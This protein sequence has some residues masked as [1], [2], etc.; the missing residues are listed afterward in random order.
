MSSVNTTTPSASGTSTPATGTQST[1]TPT[2]VPAVT[3]PNIP[4]TTAPS[5]STPTTTSGM[6]SSDTTT[7]QTT[8]PATANLNINN[9]S[10]VSGPNPTDPTNPQTGNTGT[11]QTV[12]GQVQQVIPQ[13][14]TT[15]TPATT[16]AGSFDPAVVAQERPDL[17]AAYNANPN[18]FGSASS[19][20]QFV[21][22]WQAAVSA[23][24]SMDPTGYASANGQLGPNAFNSGGTTTP[25]TTTTGPAQLSQQQIQT[26]NQQNQAAQPTLPPGATITTQDIA[27]T[28]DTDISPNVGQVTGTS[29]Y[30]A[31][32]ATAGQVGTVA[33]LAPPGTIAPATY[34]AATVDPNS[35][36]MSVGSMQTVQGQLQNL[37]NF[38]PNQPTPLWAQSAVS[39]ANQFLAAR[40]ITGSSMAGQAITQALVSA[41]LPIAQSDAS[42]YQQT[43]LAN[44]QAQVS[45]MLSNQSATNAA[46]QF[47]ATSTNQTN[48]FMATLANNVNTFNAQQMNSI[49]EFNAS[50]TQQA[51]L[52][53]ASQTNQA[54]QFDD[55]QQ[56]AT[57]QFNANNSM[58][59]A[60]SNANWRRQ[61]NTSNTAAANA[62]TQANATNTLGI[63]NQAQA[64]LWQQAMD[65]ATWSFTSTENAK[66][67]GA[68]IATAMLNANSTM[69]IAGMQSNNALYS[70]I[71]N[72]AGGL[73]NTVV[74]AS[75]VLSP[76]TGT[77]TDT[78]G[79]NTST[80]GVTGTDYTGGQE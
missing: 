57:D 70:S 24:P 12:N 36:N 35:A 47:N 14:T 41:A 8:T 2:T 34:S 79:S 54:Q 38:D 53:N 31:T 25:G 26:I 13:T 51:N 40:G 16:T 56:N 18:E 45:F 23:N 10:S 58:V 32:S 65:Q 60:Q 71:G 37:L 68:S 3:Q 21:Q 72:F 30:N 5:S 66:D 75:G 46:S 52:F 39:S 69:A 9:N 55:Q 59:I 7:S 73:F 11:T 33:T 42:T 44:Q 64:N 49:G 74:K 17:V 48:E 77:N 76:S 63:S 4:I 6:Q 29:T 78:T 22:N 28:P 61:I 19:L 50:N 15:T 27:D 67:R 20:Q 80:G 62:A 43:A 1:G